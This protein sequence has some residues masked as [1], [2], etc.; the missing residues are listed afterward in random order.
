MLSSILL[1]F[2]VVESLLRD[3]DISKAYEPVSLPTDFF[4]FCV[5]KFFDKSRYLNLTLVRYLNCG[6]NHWSYLSTRKKDNELVENYE[7]ISLL[8]I[9]PKVLEI[10]IFKR[11]INHLHFLFYLA[12][13]IPAW[14]FNSHSDALFLLGITSYCKLTHK[15][16]GKVIN[17]NLNW[18]SHVSSI[19]S[20]ASSTKQLTLLSDPKSSALS[21]GALCDPM[22]DILVKCGRRLCTVVVYKQS[23]EFNVEPEILF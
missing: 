7:P 2:S 17:T 21:T 10:R 12:T 11:C 22:S 14:P 18:S 15:N 5:C 20:K 23:M 6:N 13:R 8:C 9:L 1:T 3:L 4:F 16:I 19:L